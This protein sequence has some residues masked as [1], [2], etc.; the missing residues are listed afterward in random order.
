MI[1]NRIENTHRSRNKNYEGVELL[2]NLEEFIEWFSKNDYEGCSVDRID[3]DGNYE[4]SNMQIIPT[5]ANCGK[6]K[7]RII[8]RKK[9]CRACKEYKSFEDMVKSKRNLL[10]GLDDICRSCER[11]RAKSRREN[12][13]EAQKEA[14]RASFRRW[15]HKN[16][17]STGL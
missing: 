2:V 11:V 17:M 8:D 12:A 16:K 1:K 3:K 15:Y 5:W 7:L 14:G 10:T 9:E 13:T 6:D 4:L